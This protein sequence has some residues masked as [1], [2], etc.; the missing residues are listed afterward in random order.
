MVFRTVYGGVAQLGARLNGI[1]KV[2]GSNPH[3]SIRSSSDSLAL[4]D[5][6]RMFLLYRMVAGAVA[7]LCLV[8]A[9]SLPCR[10]QS[11][12]APSNGDPLIELLRGLPDVTI[13][14]IPTSGDTA[15]VS[16]A[17]RK[18]V[19]HMRVRQDIGKLAVNGWSVAGIRITDASIRPDD[20]IHAPVTT[21]AEFSLVKA[22][23]VVNNAPA[24]LPYLQAFQENDHI[25]VVFNLSDLKPYNGVEDFVSDAL[26]VRRM[27]EVNAYHYEALIQ[28]HKGRLPELSAAAVVKT[29]P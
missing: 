14:V 28:D 26:V 8:C 13:F 18:R 9:L 21:G 6:H 12:P 22:R 15:R 24:V 29:A 16:L 23:Q 11:G 27:P 5:V 25:S 4:L 19:P 20:T 1:E 3:T 10:A 17:Y 7:C 2:W